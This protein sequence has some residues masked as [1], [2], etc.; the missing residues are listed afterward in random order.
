MIGPP[1]SKMWK[2]LVF[3]TSALSAPPRD[4]SSGSVPSPRLDER[5]DAR[6]GSR[7]PAGGSSGLVEPDCGDDDAGRAAARRWKSA[8]G[9]MIANLPSDDRALRVDADAREAHAADGVEQPLHRD[10][11]RTRSGGRTSPASRASVFSVACLAVVDRLAAVLQLADV[12]LRL[13]G[14]RVLVEQVADVGELVLAGLDLGL[15]RRDLEVARVDQARDAVVLAA[16]LRELL[17]RA[18]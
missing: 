13:E 3:W 8:T 15:D 2:R 12:D 7:P 5:P 10:G 1:F 14:A 17:L 11:R 18:R 16:E 6:P 9:P 4:G